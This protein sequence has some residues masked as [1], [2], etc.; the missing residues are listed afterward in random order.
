MVF[1][2]YSR[3]KANVFFLLYLLFFFFNDT[4]TTEI[5]TLSLHDAPPITAIASRASATDPAMPRRPGR[6]PTRRSRRKRTLPSASRMYCRRSIAIR[7]LS[8]DAMPDAGEAT[9]PAAAPRPSAGRGHT[10]VMKF[11]GT[12]VA[13]ADRIKR[14]A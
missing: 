1:S 10:V 12:S 14:A 8:F 3:L 2:G 6:A 13:D 9:A 5:Y 4:A 11:G 7:K